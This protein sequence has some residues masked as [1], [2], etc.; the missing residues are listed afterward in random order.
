MTDMMAP[1]QAESQSKDKAHSLKTK[2]VNYMVAEAGELPQIQGQPTLRYVPVQPGL[3]CQ[4]L[5]TKQN[6]TK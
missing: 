4:K 2:V 5:K 3:Q 6:K 1:L